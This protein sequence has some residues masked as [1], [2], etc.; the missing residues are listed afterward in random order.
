MTAGCLEK[1]SQHQQPRNTNFSE[2]SDVKFSFPI[3]RA[4][5]CRGDLAD[6][7]SSQVSGPPATV[8]SRGRRPDRNLP[9][10]LEPPLQHNTEVLVYRRD[11]PEEDIGTYASECPLVRYGL[12]Q[13]WAIGLTS[14]TSS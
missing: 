8:N 11:N 13:Y 7:L 4:V 9:L 6:T 12:L 2:R 5:W 3:V 1:A 10:L 14:P